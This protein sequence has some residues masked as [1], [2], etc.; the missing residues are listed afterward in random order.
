VKSR[1][2]LLLLL[3]GLLFV[4]PDAKA[5]FSRAFGW[6]EQ[7]GQAIV[8]S[9]LA[10]APLAQAS[11]PQCTITIFL[12]GTTTPATIYSD[13]GITPLGGGTF[14]ASANGYWFFYAATGTEVDIQESGSGLSTF[15]WGDVTVGNASSSSP[16]AVNGAVVP[17]P[18]LQNGPNL[19]W[20][21][22]GSN[23][24]PALVGVPLLGSANSFTGANSFALAP[25]VAGLPIASITGSPVPGHCA[26]FTAILIIG[27]GGVCGGSS[28]SVN[29]VLISNPNFQNAATIVFGASGGNIT[30]SVAGV[31]LL[32][33][34]NAFTAANSFSTNPTFL[35]NPAL[36][37]SGLITPGHCGSF[38]SATVLQDAGANCGTG[39]SGSPAGP[40]GS[41]QLYHL[42]AFSS[43]P[44]FGMDS[45][46]SPTIL[47]VPAS[48]GVLG[49]GPWYDVREYNAIPYPFFIAQENTTATC[50]A[51]TGNCT[52][53]A[54]MNFKNGEGVVIYTGGAPNTQS[55]PS[56]PTA[57]SPAVTGS[58]NLHYQCTGID[59][60]G[61]ITQSSPSF[62]LSSAPNIFAP[63]P[64]VISSISVTAN[65]ATVN[66]STPINAT[67]GNVQHISISGVTGPG[68]TWNGY[69]LVATAPTASQITYAITTAN[70]TGTVSSTSLGRLTNTAGITAISRSGTTISITTDAAHNFI[71][72]TGGTANTL[73]TVNGVTPTDLN[74]TYK[75][76]TASGSAITA[77]SAISATESGSVTVGF[78]TAT[79]HEFITVTCPAI[80]PPTVNYAVY[81]DS[82]SGGVTLTYLGETMYGQRTFT[83]WGPLYA[84]S[85]QR[86]FYVPTSPPVAAQAQLYRGKILTGGGT[87]A[88][89]V[90]PNITTSLTS[91]IF[92][93]ESSGIQ[94]ALNAAANNGG[95]WVYLSPFASSFCQYAINYPVTIPQNV[96]LIVGAGVVGNEPVA[97]S[98]GNYINASLL[99]GCSVSQ[100][101]FGNKHYQTWS[102]NAKEFL[103]GNANDEG[104]TI[105]G[106]LFSSTLNGQNFLVFDGQGG[107]DSV[108]NSFFNATTA[109]GGTDVGITYIGGGGM[110]SHHLT[111]LGSLL[112]GPLGQGNSG[113][114][115]TGIMPFGPMLIPA[116]WF[117]GNDSGG[118]NNNPAQIYMDGTN[119]MNGRGILIDQTFCSNC[120]GQNFHF[121]HNWN[122]GATQPQV[123]FY[124]NGGGLTVRNIEVGQILEDTTCMAVFASWSNL[125]APTTLNEDTSGC[126]VGLV[127][128]NQVPGL[129]V[130]GLQSGNSVGQ[131]TDVVNFPGQGAP[132]FT[133][134]SS[135]Y[136]QDSNGN[137][138]E[139]TL[140]QTAASN[141]AGTSACVTSTKTITFPVAY[142]NT[143]VITVS[144]ETTTG[145]ARVSAHSNS[146]F[147]VT[148][149]GATDAFDYVVVGNPN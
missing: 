141:F 11:Y 142:V 53:A 129:I 83:D 146:A 66:F 138:T 59:A 112:Y 32:A 17:L 30:A 114:S 67:G 94:A 97:R 35:G 106:I 36:S 149:T 84:S 96:D 62:T 93:D 118:A 102:G 4:C 40:E 135:T 125:I 26:T 3:L 47:N 109:A 21:V 57:T 74:G 9:G 107:Y 130:V 119:T 76:L 73:V 124:G 79:V 147:T 56:A 2:H 18:N 41:V 122:Q 43:I 85:P 29:G 14:K 10:G 116:I 34:A 39:G 31:P 98:G 100:P 139:A 99:G 13:K 63:Q 137:V 70:G 136:S 24:T 120:T 12:T 48:L 101:Q 22:V 20:T 95:G 80:S 86:R 148:C 51:G 77:Q 131:N 71:A 127:T 108:K 68:A 87:T 37:V 113:G 103:H 25:L 23:V 117:R 65:V 126:G 81:G 133:V 19:N 134:Q 110:S 61:A 28:I 50:T 5:Q 38:L 55:T 105:E 144:D 92:H 121:D 72:Q 140:N 46:T 44:N 111:D 52:L 6:C 90:T 75:V 54:A 128:G 145:G 91:A 27:D 49:P 123:M 45:V 115:Q 16:L 58:S 82:P 7:G 104:D 88:I 78:S 64:V 132:K 33:S 60:L 69:W 15:T 8:V 1:L 89:T 143:P 42:G